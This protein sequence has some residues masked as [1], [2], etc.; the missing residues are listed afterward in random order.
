MSTSYIAVTEGVDKKVATHS[1]V[2]DSE[3][4]HI[5]RIAYGAGVLSL[6]DSPQV[7]SESGSTVYPIQNNDPDSSMLTSNFNN[8][9]ATYSVDN[10]TST[11][12][13]DTNGNSINDYLQIDLGSDNEKD[14]V[15]LGLYLSQAGYDGKFKVQYS[16]DGSNWYDASAEW[17]PNNSGWNY[18]YWDYVGKHRYWRILLTQT[19]SSVH[20]DFMEMQWFDTTSIDCQGKGKIVIK[21]TFNDNLASC[22]FRLLF[23]DNNDVLIGH[24]DKISLS[25]STFKDNNRYLTNEGVI[26]ISNDCGAKS[27]KMRIIDLTSDDNVTIYAGAI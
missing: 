20:G 13:W 1:F 6:P 11:K 21:L 8:F 7:D 25:A 10:N 16:D 9:N 2:E 5:E 22:S 3:I 19:S 23:Y 15:K 17:Q 12:G 26:V 14:Y 4:K 18:L 24:T 27:F